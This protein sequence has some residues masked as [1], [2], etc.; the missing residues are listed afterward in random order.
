M[1]PKSVR[2][3]LALVVFLI[4]HFQFGLVDD[5]IAFYIFLVVLSVGALWEMGKIFLKWKLKRTIPEFDLSK[6]KNPAPKFALRAA[7]E[8]FS[9]A[10]ESLYMVTETTGATG[11]CY[12]NSLEILNFDDKEAKKILGY[13]MESSWDITSGATA[14]LQIDHLLT[15]ATEGAHLTL[16]DVHDN[17]TLQRFRDYLA[18]HQSAALPQGNEVVTAFDLIR[19]SWLA[20]A[21][22]SCGHLTENEAQGYLATTGML[23]QQQFSSWRELAAS[24]LIGYLA[25]NGGL[26]DA[27]SSVMKEYSA[28]ERVL[29]VNLV[30]G[31][32]ASPI[33]NRPFS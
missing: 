16:G 31:N 17:E 6:L 12:V 13:S 5:K 10:A 1:N 22:F 9:A 28:K 20:R 14:M 2:L 21:S 29:G 23:I 32:E 15:S 19:A 8:R 26:D 11:D 18:S 30:L 27:L 33:F 3:T 24:Y 4:A 7:S 25:W